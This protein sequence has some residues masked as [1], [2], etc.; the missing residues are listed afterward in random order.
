MRTSGVLLVQPPLLWDHR[1]RLSFQPPLNLL[2]LHGYLQARG[3]EVGLLDVVSHECT[4]EGAVERVLAAAPALV[5]IPL[6]HASLDTAFALVS[7]LRARAPDLRFIAGGPCMTME[8]E[9]MMREG[10]FDFGIIGE[11]EEPL[12]AL[13]SAVTAGSGSGASFASLPGLAYRQGGNILDNPRPAPIADLDA[14]PFLDFSVLDNEFYFS[15]Q[16]RAGVPRTL[17]LNSSRGCSFRCTYC[18]TPVLWPG[19]IRRFSPPRLIE[20]IRFQ[21]EQFPGVEIGFCDDSFFA[22]RHW[23]RDFLELARPLGVKFQCIGRADHL[24]AEDIGRLVEAGLTYIAFGVET[25][26]ALRQRALRKN[27][28]LGRLVEVMRA[29]G[30]ERVKTKCFFMLGFPD[31]TPAEMAETI[32]LASSLKRNGMTFFS[33]FPVTVYPGTELA[34]Q[35]GNPPCRIGIDAHLPE[36]I[37]DDLAISAEQAELLKS[38]YNSLMTRRQMVDLV[39]YAYER[40]ERGATV[41]AAE[42]ERV[43]RS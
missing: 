38:P 36:I 16:E 29:L 8:P 43:I 20:E 1:L 3:I 28:D 17:F 39:T 34:R 15:R 22:D 4:L 10:G 13:V 23:L 19:T 40:V 42:L 31:E 14:L 11:G 35:F 30:R 26:S 5:G 37:R 2:A 32:N 9:R 7:T 6:Y 18:C 25:G 27:L 12:A 24:T 41:T 33:I 21:L